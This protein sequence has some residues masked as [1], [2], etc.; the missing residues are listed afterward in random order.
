MGDGD[1]GTGV[2]VEEAF[3]PGHGLGVQVVGG[4][5]E[6]QHVGLGQQQ[7]AQGHPAPLAA[8]ELGHV[9]VPGR[10]AQGL[11]G[12]LQGAVQVVA[13]GGLDQVLQLG[14]L[15]GQGVEI[16]VRL[17]VG[18]IDGIQA[19]QGG[20]DM[21]Q[22]LLDIAAHILGGV[23]LG[24]L[25]QEADLDAGLRPGLALDLGVEAGHDAQQGGFARAVDA[26]HADLG[27]GE[28]GQGDVA[29]DHALGRH[30]L[31]DPIHCVDI[32]RHG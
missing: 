3:Q 18:G 30:D 28:E 6:E 27:A 21:A 15:L 5:V 4:L 24:L 22:G 26:E 25:G 29:Q 9:G 12:Y 13:V 14:L 8:G 2:F 31:A 16:S 11:G 10:Q 32:L 17:G 23:E 7:S 20:L 19:L 1:D